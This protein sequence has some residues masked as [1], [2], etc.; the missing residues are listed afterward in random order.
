[1]WCFDHLAGLF[2]GINA[3]MM[4]ID[5]NLGGNE[6]VVVFDRVG[7]LF[8]S[9]FA[10]VKQFFPMTVRSFLHS[11]VSSFLQCTVRSFFR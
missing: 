1:M 5:L 3:D 8:P 10:K 7:K 9:L 6:P 11:P 2:A 4:L